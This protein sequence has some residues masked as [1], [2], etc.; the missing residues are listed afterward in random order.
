MMVSQG[1]AVGWEQ[2]EEQEKRI[3]LF[4]SEETRGGASDEVAPDLLGSRFVVTGVREEGVVGGATLLG[5]RLDDR[6]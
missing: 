5:V 4:L 1:M 2:S 6:I 3:I